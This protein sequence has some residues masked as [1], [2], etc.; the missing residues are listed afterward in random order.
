VPYVA[1]FIGK[2][3]LNDSRIFL[4]IGKAPAKPFSAPE[5]LKVKIKGENAFGSAFDRYSQRL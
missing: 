3:L 5:H 1:V 2:G 4:P